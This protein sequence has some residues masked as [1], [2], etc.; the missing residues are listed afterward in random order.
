MVFKNTEQTLCAGCQD[1]IILKTSIKKAGK[2][3]MCKCAIY[4]FSDYLTVTHLYFSE[5]SH[6]IQ[7]NST[8]A[9]SCSICHAISILC[10][11]QDGTLYFHHVMSQMMVTAGVFWLTV[12]KTPYLHSETKEHR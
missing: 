4:A 12:L 1:Y 9:E 6:H 5:V 2:I 11:F 8:L 7:G 3:K 10:I